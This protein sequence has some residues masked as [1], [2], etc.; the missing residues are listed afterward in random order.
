MNQSTGSQVDVE[1]DETVWGLKERWALI[2]GLSVIDHRMTHRGKMLQDEKT[3][4]QE[5]LVGGETLFCEPV[6]E[7][8]TGTSEICNVFRR[9]SIVS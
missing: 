5:G 4:R 9:R 6:T 8:E 7:P 1:E 3:L 2:T